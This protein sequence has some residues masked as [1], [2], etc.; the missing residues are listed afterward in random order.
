MKKKI[1]SVIKSRFKRK[2]KAVYEPNPK[3]NIPHNVSMPGVSFYDKFEHH[4]QNNKTI[5]PVI[6]DKMTWKLLVKHNPVLRRLRSEIIV[7]EK[8]NFPDQAWDNVA[9]RLVKVLK[10]YHEPMVVSKK[11]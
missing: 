11:H 7:A 9:N 4:L 8:R 1:T 5:V 3:L 2:E 6:D 10:R